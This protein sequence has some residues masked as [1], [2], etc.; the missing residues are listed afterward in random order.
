MIVTDVKWIDKGGVLRVGYYMDDYLVE[1]LTPIPDFLAKDRDIVAITSGRGQV[2]NGK[3]TITIGVAYFIAWLIAGGR[4][5][6]EKDEEGRFINPRVIQ[7]PTKPVRFGLENFAYTPDDLIA[8]GKDLYDKYGK[9]QILFYDEC[10]GL[11]SKGTMKS[12][13]QKLEE[14]FQTCGAYN[15]VIL[16]VLPNFFKLNEDI[17][18]T[19]SMFLIDCYS[20]ENWKR[21]FFDYYGP[22]DKEWLYFNGK[23][24]LGVSAK[25]FSQAPSFYGTFRDWLPFNR[26]EYERQKREALK[27]KVFGSR[28]ERTREKL[29]GVLNVLKT[30]TNL[31][32]KEIAEG[33]SKALFKEI[34]AITLEHDIANYQRYIE[35]H[36]KGR[37]VS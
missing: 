20:D 2:R 15:H 29:W 36:Q 30:N 34:T 17:A 32:T 1:N 28:E 16:V 9:Q 35:K 22:K 33:V 6:M 18:T 26:E 10:S 24:R 37:D 19:R 7:K 23:K 31:T 13:N 3:S 12:V 25:Y 21:G 5:D 4:M 11:D 14:F 27:K 8:K